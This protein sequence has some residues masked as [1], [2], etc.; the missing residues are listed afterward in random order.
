MKEWKKDLHQV[1][2]SLTEISD[3]AAPRGGGGGII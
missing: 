2:A 3:I 1:E